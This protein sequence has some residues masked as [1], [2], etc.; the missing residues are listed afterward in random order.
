[1]NFNPD[2]AIDLYTV[3]RNQVQMIMD[4]GYNP[5]NLLYQDY[6]N[7]RSNDIVYVNM[8]NDDFV[9]DAWNNVN[10]SSNPK[11]FFNAL[12]INDNTSKTLR[13]LYLEV[14]RGKDEVSVNSIRK[15]QTKD[16]GY[17]NVLSLNFGTGKVDSILFV[18]PKKLNIHATR[19]IQENMVDMGCSCEVF[20]W[21]E[22]LSICPNHLFN[23]DSEIIPKNNEKDI[24]KSFFRNPD[25]KK[26]EFYASFTNSLPIVLSSDIIV[27]YYGAKTKDIIM[28]KSEVFTHNSLLRDNISIRK[29]R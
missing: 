22:L 26:D 6:N 4:R 7:P 20:T 18:T 1:M 25:S 13:V 23:G 8:S 5:Y 3:K 19:E 9:M 12:Y 17:Q 24:I 21:I 16:L 2:T 15:Y 29:V 14:E 10:F 27:R 11:D 28:T